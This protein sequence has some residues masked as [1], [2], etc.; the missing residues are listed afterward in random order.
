LKLVLVTNIVV[1]WVALLRSPEIPDSVV[2]G[3]RYKLPGPDYSAYVFVFL[4]SVI[5]C[6]YTN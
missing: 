4:G 5:I 1:E 6:R 3:S 2:G